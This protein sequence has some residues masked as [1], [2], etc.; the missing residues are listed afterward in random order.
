MTKATK[1]DTVSSVPNNIE[2]R[3]IDMDT[4]ELI[5][6]K[7]QEARHTGFIDGMI[8]TFLLILIATA[9]ISALVAYNI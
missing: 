1:N 9:L 6:R 8:S 5:L 3:Y 4:Y 7:E 2:Y